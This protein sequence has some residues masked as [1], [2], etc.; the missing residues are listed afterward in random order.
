MPELNFHID[1]SR[2]IRCGACIRDCAPAILEFDPESGFPRVIPGTDA[3][4]TRCQHCLAVCPREAV[5]IFGRDPA[6]SIPG[7]TGP[8]PGA[9]L[10][11][12]AN[13]RSVRSYRHENLDRG[14]LDKLQEMLRYVPTGVNSHT[15]H[16]AFIDEVEVMDSFRDYVSGKIADMLETDPQNPFLTRM[17]RYRKQF[18]AG[19][20][21]IF[22]NAPHMVVAAAK[23]G[24]P[25]EAQDPFIALSYFELYAQSL[26]VGTL[27][28]GLAQG[29]LAYF[30]EL[31]ARLGLP[32]G[33]KASYSM[34]FGPP[35]VRYPRAVQPDPVGIHSVR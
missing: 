26:G 25:C 27:W 29:A 33:W 22:R 7:G 15:L 12:I 32:E 5:G 10:S 28:C 16:F 23:T 11:L 35:N 4:C 3:G 18:V 2:C 20:D 9:M 1:E 8:A 14:T 30:P 34:L 21:V 6:K 31:M 17:E 19:R 24:T 13:R